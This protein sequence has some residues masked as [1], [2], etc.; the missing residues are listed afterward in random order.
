MLRV[1]II[2]FLK[3]IFLIANFATLNKILRFNSN[4]LVYTIIPIKFI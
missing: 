3:I 2:D 1:S 4:Q